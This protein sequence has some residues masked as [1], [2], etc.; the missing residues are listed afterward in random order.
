MG[1]PRSF[2]L[3]DRDVDHLSTDADAWDDDPLDA[4][5]TD[6]AVNS[7]TSVDA[8]ARVDAA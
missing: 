8:D 6:N 7:D 4:D 1:K 3:R 5:D 2:A